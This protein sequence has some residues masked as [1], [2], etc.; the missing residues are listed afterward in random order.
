MLERKRRRRGV[1]HRSMWLCGKDSYPSLGLRFERFDYAD[2]SFPGLQG[3][4]FNGSR[5]DDAE[6]GSGVHR[7]DDRPSILLAQDDVAGKECPYRRLHGQRPMSERR[8]ARAEDQIRQALDTELGLHGG[9]DVDLGQ[10]AET[11]DLEGS[12]CLL[13]TS[14]SPRD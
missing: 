6:D 3:D 14:P 10:D 1:F 8:I 9:R 13:Y 4:R 7:L 5:F 2:Q 11:L 12:F